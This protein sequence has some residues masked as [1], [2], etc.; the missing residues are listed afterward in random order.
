MM[1]P[2]K[3]SLDRRIE[4]MY[5]TMIAY[6]RYPICCAFLDPSCTVT[7]QKWKRKSSSRTHASR[8]A[9]WLEG[10]QHVDTAIRYT[11]PT[12]PGNSVRSHSLRYW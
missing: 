12:L 2:P 8:E 3:R 9:S 4:D 10:T 1:N 5:N 6:Y 11:F 7:N